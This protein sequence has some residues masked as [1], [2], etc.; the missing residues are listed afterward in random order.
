MERVRE[1][2]VQEPDKEAI[3]FPVLNRAITYSQLNER[4]DR[5]A[6]WLIGLGLQA[7]DGIALLFENHPAIPEIAIGAERAGLYYTP[8]S[9]QLKIRE[10]A[11]V[12][13]DCGAR[14][15]IVSTAMGQLAQALVAAGGAAGVA[16]FMVGGTAPGFTSYETAIAQTDPSRPL[17]RRD[18]GCDFLYSSGTTGLPKGIRTPLIPHGMRGEDLPENKSLRETFGFDGNTIYLSTA[19]LYHAAPLRYLM[20]MLMFGGRTI[21]LQKFDPEAALDAIERF[22][23]T[24]SQWVPT[25]FVRLLNLS[26]EVRTRYDLSSLRVAI[27]AAAPC[28]P[29]V[30]ERMIEWFGPVIYEY[31][32]GSESVGVTAI[33][34]QEWLT[35]RGSV[36]RAICGVLHILDDDDCE[37]PAG[38]IGRVFFSDGPTFEYFNDPIKTRAAHNAKG[39]ATYGDIGHID[40]DGY[41]YLSDRRVDLIISGGVNLYPQE[42]ENVLSEHPAVAD[43]AVIGVP[44][45]EFGEEV[46][47]IVQPHEPTTANPALAAELIAFCRDRLSNI[48]V[49]RTVEFEA[50][51]P[52]H[53]NGKMLRRLLKERYR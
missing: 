10:I 26:D 15:L 16:C 31:Y 6:H 27:H 7:G 50:P 37:L 49:P 41:L 44:N 23:I 36:G 12:L 14:V 40:G 39:W 9:T 46:K 48:K 18:H 22:R 3:R 19:P 45:P 4:A 13:K 47:A 29:A 32:S 34:S 52:R 51:L 1:L 21:V 28:P 30:K 43:V 17:P 20:R 8:I 11:H 38:E 5:V 2:A 24:H 33:D 35:H 53:D 25:M 42:I